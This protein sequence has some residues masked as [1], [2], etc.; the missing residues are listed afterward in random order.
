MANKDEL[1]SQ[2]FC[3]LIRHC[4]IPTNQIGTVYQTNMYFYICL[5]T[6]FVF[7]VRKSDLKLIFVKEMQVEE[8]VFLESS[9]PYSS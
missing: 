9:P 3:E 6:K 8:L 7:M 4:K 1:K 2:N 5:K